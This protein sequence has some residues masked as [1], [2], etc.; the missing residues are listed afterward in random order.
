MTVETFRVL[1][2]RG[3]SGFDM[4][5]SCDTLDNEDLALLRQVL[6]EVCAEKKIALGSH[7]AAAIGRELVN[8]Y[9]FGVKHP[10][11]LKAMLKPLA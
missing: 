3:W 6:E 8:W 10:H 4:F 9:L 5:S 11:Q 7:E 2:G 1:V